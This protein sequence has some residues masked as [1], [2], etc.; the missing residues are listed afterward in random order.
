MNTSLPTWLSGTARAQSP[1][2]SAPQKIS[3]ISPSPK[4]L[5][6]WSPPMGRI[7]PGG[8]A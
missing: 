7:V 6:A 1:P 2:E 5:W 4:P 8:S 3:T